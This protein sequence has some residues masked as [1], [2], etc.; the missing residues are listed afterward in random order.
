MGQVLQWGLAGSGAGGGVAGLWGAETSVYNKLEEVWKFVE[1][2]RGGLMRRSWV[3][4][5]E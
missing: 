5:S 3:Y 1:S 4:G 2:D